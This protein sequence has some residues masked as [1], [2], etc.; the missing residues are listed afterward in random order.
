MNFSKIIINGIN[1][2]LKANIIYN[3][4]GDMSIT[5]DLKKI[6]IL[7]YILLHVQVHAYMI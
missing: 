1:I 6:I 5:N 7:L 2:N 3:Y 4:G